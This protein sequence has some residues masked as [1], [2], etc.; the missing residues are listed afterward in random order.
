MADPM[1]R[2][3]SPKKGDWLLALGIAVSLALILA[4]N[5]LLEAIPEGYG[6]VSVIVVIAIV[7][8]VPGYFVARF[9]RRRM[10]E[11]RAVRSLFLKVSI[12]TEQNLQDLRR[13]RAQL[14]QPGDYGIVDFEKWRKELIKFV[15]RSIGP[16][17]SPDEFSALQRS[18][19]EVLRSIDDMIL[20]SLNMDPAFQAFSEDMTPTEFEHF[21]ADELRRSGWKARVTTQSGDQGVDVLAEKNGVSVVIQCK[22]Y[23]G[24]VS[25]KSVQEV[26][27][28][29]IHYEAVHA[30][31][32]S[33]TRYTPS[34]KQLAA[35]NEVWLLHY[36][37][38]QNLDSIL[39]IKI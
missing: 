12:S 3:R 36:S 17:L 27:A 4:I 25:N 9:A 15:S 22:L 6:P 35:T 37:E 26:A 8:L 1:A 19:A 32:V 10:Q 38:L 29:R 16:S 33:K 23:S 2:R 24:A 11:N 28:G 39:G 34:A 30:A 13:N 20:A 31:V 7:A 14:V 18:H 21:C 5:R